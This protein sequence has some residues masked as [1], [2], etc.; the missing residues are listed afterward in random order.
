M[1][2]GEDLRLWIEDR[3]RQRMTSAA[4]EAARADWRTGPVHQHFDALMKGLKRKTAA[5]VAEA[6]WT[7]F[8]N[9][10]WVDVLVDRLA[11]PMRAD[12][13]FQPPFPMLTSEINSGLLV[14]E[15]DHVM[16]TAS[17]SRA[18]QLAVK[19]SGARGPGSI[20]FSGQVN[21]L[22]FVKAGDATLSF[23]EASPI[24][25]EFMAARVGLCRHTG[26]RRIEDG[27]LL[28]V[29]GR[30]QSYVIDHA[31]ANLLVLQAIIKTEQ[32]PLAVEYDA[33][34]GAYLGCSA[35]DDADTRIQM[36][37]TLIRKLGR[38]GAFDEVAA[39]LGHPRFFVR[40][41]VM[42]E[43]IGLDARAALPHL[44]RMATRDPHGDVRQAAGAALAQIAAALEDREA[45]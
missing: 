24:T 10:A 39:H 42:R 38:D 34:T 25:A 4:I 12:P 16:V 21:I 29:D 44:R 8:A 19:K 27:A 30:S 35:T 3:D 2:V 9:D 1:I 13:F 17:V 43:L 37:A 45:A 33:A 20:N 18:G 23:W 14:F 6:Y 26:T 40:W 32:A 28:V 31:R 41:H 7:L 36:L 22:K 15:D 11:T 5:T